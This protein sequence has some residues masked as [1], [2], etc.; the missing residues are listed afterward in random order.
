VIRECYERGRSKAGVLDNVVRLLPPLNI[1]DSDLQAG[2][3]IFEDALS[4]VHA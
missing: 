2:L 1:P 3:D 4:A